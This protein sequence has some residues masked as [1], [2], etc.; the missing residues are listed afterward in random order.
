MAGAK[1]ELRAWIK[2][3]LAEFICR[4]MGKNAEEPEG[5]SDVQGHLSPEIPWFPLLLRLPD[6]PNLDDQARYSCR[7]S[8]KE[9]TGVLSARATIWILRR[10]AS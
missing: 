6:R 7:W 1:P 9:N 2:E 8:P 4:E 5:A 10:L 3:F